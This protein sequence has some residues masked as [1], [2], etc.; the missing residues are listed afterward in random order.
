M[1]LKK[2]LAQS[3]CTQMIQL[4]KMNNSAEVPWNLFITTNTIKCSICST[5]SENSN[6]CFEFFVSGSQSNSTLVLEKKSPVIRRKGESQNRGKKKTNLLESKICLFFEKFGL[7]CFLVT[8][9]LWFVFFPYYRRSFHS[10]F[11][12][13]TNHFYHSIVNT[14][15][16]MWL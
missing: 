8:S 12:T 14:W 11:L 7:L 5:W 9:V 1:F 4:A 10:A 15:Q 2:L 6:L 3:H 13:Q 16:V